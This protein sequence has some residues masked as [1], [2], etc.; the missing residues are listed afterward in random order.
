[1]WICRAELEQYRDLTHRLDG[2]MILSRQKDP[3]NI[4]QEMLLGQMDKDGRSRS[5]SS[6]MVQ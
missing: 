4:Q 2:E 1:M 3:S 6:E 5:E